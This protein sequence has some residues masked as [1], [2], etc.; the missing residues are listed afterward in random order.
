MNRN[1]NQEERQSLSKLS[2]L[3]GRFAQTG[4]DMLTNTID[5]KEIVKTDLA[6]FLLFRQTLEMGDALSKLIEAGCINASK[7]LVRTL[8]EY[9]F[10]LAYLFNSD[11]ERKSLQFLYHYEKRKKEYYE[12]HETTFVR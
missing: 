6:S 10:Q 11:E 3:I 7:P 2:D 5:S 9:Y 12:R 1:Y 4:I 8:S